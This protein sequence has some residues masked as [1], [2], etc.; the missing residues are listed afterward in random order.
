MI[1]RWLPDTTLTFAYE[2]YVRFH[3]TTREALIGTKI[4]DRIQEPE[5]EMVRHKV[6]RML[7]TSE[8]QTYENH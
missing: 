2:T 5:R 7:E 4:L 1:C 3:E 8:T 6:A